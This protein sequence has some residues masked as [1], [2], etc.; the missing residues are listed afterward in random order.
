VCW[1][2]AAK[3]AAPLAQPA[4]GNDVIS[5]LSRQIAFYFSDENLAR[6]LYLR[7]QMDPFASYVSIALIAGFRNVRTI[8]DSAVAA[9]NVRQ[10]CP[11]FS[12][13]F[14]FLNSLFPRCWSW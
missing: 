12:P 10:F 11:F 7:K 2:R 14:F 6:D 5:R 1:Y 3:P 9:A 8:C 13:P 4:L